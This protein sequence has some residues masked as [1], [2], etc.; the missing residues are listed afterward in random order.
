MPCTPGLSASPV[1]PWKQ[2]AQHV[3][4]DLR[5]IERP[6][7]N[8][9]ELDTPAGKSHRSILRRPQTN[10]SS[11]PD[12]R[13]HSRVWKM[14]ELGVLRWRPHDHCGGNF[15]FLDPGEKPAVGGPILRARLWP[16]TCVNSTGMGTFNLALDG[17]T[18]QCVPGESDLRKQ[19]VQLPR[20]PGAS[21]SCP[22]Y[23]S[24]RIHPWSRLPKWASLWH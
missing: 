11:S 20:T 16:V 9:I 12:R 22:A 21:G 15:E 1:I 2:I 10:G 18:C 17:G 6:L 7:S 19:V 23:N 8:T 4:Y 24:R 5:T 3:G 13:T 14:P